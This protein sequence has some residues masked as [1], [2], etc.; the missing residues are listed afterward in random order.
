MR[1]NV[2]TNTK[3]TS[4]CI[5]DLEEVKRPARSKSDIPQREKD[6]HFVFRAMDVDKWD[7]SISTDLVLQPEAYRSM[8]CELATLQIE[9]Q[10]PAFTACSFISRV[11]CLLLF[12]N[13]EKLKLL[14]T[15]SVLIE[16]S[17]EPTLTLDD[18][19]TKESEPITDRAIPCPLH[20][21]GWHPE[22]FCNLHADYFLWVFWDYLAVFI[23][24]LEGAQ[25]IIEVVPA[26]F[27]KHSVELAL[28]KFFRV[29]RSV[30]TSALIDMKVS[31]PDECATYLSWLFERL[32]EVLSFHPKMV[33][34]EAY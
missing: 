18:F 17:T 21:S 14:L 16:G 27:L 7:Y 30:K 29:V 9:D 22:K 32:A 10:Y 26:V 33:K 5:L 12:S 34:M 28:R 6:L 31:T 2:M 25:R 24:Y 11:Q 23:G 19:I 3:G 15:G 8:V 4:T 1:K 13:N 20:N